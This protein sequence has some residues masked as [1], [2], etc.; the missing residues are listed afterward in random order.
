MEDYVVKKKLLI[1]GLI[2]FC[3]IASKVEAQKII[4]VTSRIGNGNYMEVS[5]IVWDGNV[6]DL[7]DSSYFIEGGD[8]FQ[9]WANSD[10]EI[11]QLIGGLLRISSPV[12]NLHLDS[13]SGCFLINN[14]TGKGIRGQYDGYFLALSNIVLSSLVKRDAP[15]EVINF[16]C[17]GAGAIYARPDISQNWLTAQIEMTA[18]SFVAMLTHPLPTVGPMTLSCRNGSY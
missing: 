1:F 6:C 13:S 11:A 5:Q 4:P 12:E 15:K 16:V 17:L 8:Q 3:F 7:S 10:D 9:L 14:R 18:K 2:V